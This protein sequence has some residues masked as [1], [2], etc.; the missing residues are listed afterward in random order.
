MSVNSTEKTNEALP[1]SDLMD[2]LLGEI[3]PNV[4]ADSLVTF[5]I[6]DPEKRLVYPVKKIGCLTDSEEPVI[7]LE[8]GEGYDMDGGNE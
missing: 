2:Y 1:A 8:V 3:N 6:G 4:K 5:L 7:L